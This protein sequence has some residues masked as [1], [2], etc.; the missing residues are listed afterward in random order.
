MDISQDLIK[1]YADKL[2]K[3]DIPVSEIP[4]MKLYIEQLT[5]FMDKKLA[6]TKRD[7]EGP[8]F[9]KAMI[10]NY[11]KEKLLNPPENKKYNQEHIILLILMHHLKRVLSIQDIKTLF[12]S[13]IQNMDKSEVDDNIISLKDIYETFLELKQAEYQ[14]ITDDFTKRFEIIKA[15]TAKITNDNN[16]DTAEAFL[17]VMMLVAEA[18]AAKRLAE[19]IIDRCIRKKA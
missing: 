1:E 18:N 9:T 11:T 4:D 5:E 14:D 10:N 2:K 15:E 12:G 7:H 6:H 8:V 13:I 3:S 17:T 19:E 16:Q